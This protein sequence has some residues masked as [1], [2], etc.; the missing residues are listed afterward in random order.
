MAYF[1]WN[2]TTPM[3]PVALET[4]RGALVEDWGN[5]SA[6]YRVGAAVRSRFEA[7]REAMAAALGFSPEGVIF[8]SGAT[9]SNNA[10]LREMAL[11]LSEGELWISAVE[12]AAVRAAAARWWPGRTRHIPVR[13][14]GVIELEWVSEQLGQARPALVSVMAANNET[15][16]IQPWEELSQRCAEAGIP[17]HCDAT[18]WWGRAPEADF[19]QCTAVAMSAHKFGGPKGV[20]ALLL[21]SPEALPRLQEG[22]SQEH[23]ARAGTE[24]VPAIRAMAAAFLADRPGA[25]RQAQWRD[26][27]ERR[28]VAELPGVRVNGA[29]SPRLWN[30]SSLV[31]PDFSAR[32]W[33][34]RL[35][36]EGFQ[37]SGGAA[38][39]ASS[40]VPSVVLTEMGLSQA[41]AAR[42]VRVSGGWHT[43]EADWQGLATAIK[44]VHAALLDEAPDD[45]TRVIRFS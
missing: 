4:L 7:A 26:A 30:T 12:H 29:G 38:C 18:Q 43:T 2:A 21:K 13:G 17:F 45:L 3:E 6:P 20:G 39:S 40:E 28:L 10:Y 42:V 44:G 37:V 33:V 27:F 32:R 34:P 35:D 14:D 16:L 15:G 25:P 19:S 9:E 23:G 11:Q 22:G 8:T 5:P 31:L 24:N 41:E 1:D 36:R